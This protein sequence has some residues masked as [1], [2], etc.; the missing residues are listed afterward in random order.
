MEFSSAGLDEVRIRGVHANLYL[1]MNSKGNLYG[2]VISLPKFFKI[3][4]F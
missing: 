3:I 4:L 1:A 2:E